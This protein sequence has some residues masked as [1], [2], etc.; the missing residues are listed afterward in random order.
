V[1]S[2][3]KP[4]RNSVAALKLKEVKHKHKDKDKDKDKDIVTIPVSCCEIC[5]IIFIID[6]K[7]ILNV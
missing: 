7:S 4:I 3:D 1:T 6:S 2:P 5:E